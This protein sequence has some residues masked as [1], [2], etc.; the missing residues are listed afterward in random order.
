MKT[1]EI[2]KHNILRAYRNTSNPDVKEVLKDVFGST[3][4]TDVTDRV[5]SYQDA[6][7]ELG[8]QDLHLIDFSFL[9]ESS[10]RSAYAFHQ[11]CTIAEA[12]NEGWQ[13]N[14]DDRD[15]PK[16][17]GWFQSK[18]DGFSY[19]VLACGGVDA[20]VGSRLVY[21]SLDLAEYAGTQFIDIYREFMNIQ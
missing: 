15:Q 3:L 11:L 9:P 18:E 19:G 6:C 21:K 10:Q 2:Q 13:P 12:L 14:W 8:I 7:D 1:I 4:F 20:A 16:Y 17:H 5:K